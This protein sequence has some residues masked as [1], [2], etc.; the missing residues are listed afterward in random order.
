MVVTELDLHPKT[1]GLNRMAPCSNV[2]IAIMAVFYCS[3][4]NA[5]NK[6]IANYPSKSI[7][8][9]INDTIGIYHGE[10][11]SWDDFPFI[12]MIYNELNN[13]PC[14]GGSI[15]SLNPPTILT[16]GHCYANCREPTKVVIGCSGAYCTNSE[17]TQ[18]DIS[19][20]LV[21]PLFS[22]ATADYDI[23]LI[24]LTS[25]SITQPS[26]VET[27]SIYSPITNPASGSTLTIL[28]YGKTD[29]EAYATILQYGYEHY[30]I[31]SICA[32]LM[33]WWTPDLTPR[34]YCM[35]SHLQETAVCMGDSGSPVMIIQDNELV[36]LGIVSWGMGQSCSGALPQVQTNLA[37]VALKNWISDNTDL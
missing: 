25:S 16:A 2:F 28:G 26:N 13:D 29:K 5:N 24:Y 7:Y 33:E 30:M 18:Y 15:I 31:Q 37:N 3:Q 17:A 10:D 4:S 19:S 34:M 1:Q 6:S 8:S 22:A 23:A 21:H 12:V 35:R 32:D 9:T 36:Q 27:I 20:W 14:C 11:A